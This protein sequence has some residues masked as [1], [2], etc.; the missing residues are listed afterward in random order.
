M[1]EQ[2]AKALQKDWQTS[3]RWNGVK[4]T[5]SA[6]DVVRLRGSVHIEH[7]LARLGAEKLWR[8]MSE[9]PSQNAARAAPSRSP[10]SR[11]D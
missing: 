9:K 1:S 4:R 5:Y 6:E 2:T 8:S 10:R 11:K 3:P 7:S